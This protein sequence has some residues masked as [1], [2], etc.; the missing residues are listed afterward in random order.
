MEIG[1]SYWAA[2]ESN[3]ARAASFGSTTDSS[4]DREDVSTYVSSNC[5]VYIAV[6]QILARVL[7]ALLFEENP[8]FRRLG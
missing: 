7:L 4:F 3:P 2:H 6:L 1:V 5:V 8:A